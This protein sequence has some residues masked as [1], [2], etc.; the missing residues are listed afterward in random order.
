MMQRPRVCSPTKAR[1]PGFEPQSGSSFNQSF[2]KHSSTQGSAS[3]FDMDSPGV[4]PQTSFQDPVSYVAVDR[5]SSSSVRRRLERSS[6]SS[7]DAF[8]YGTAR[9]EDRVICRVCE[10]EVLRSLFVYSA[11]P[12]PL[13]LT[14]CVPLCTRWQKAR[15]K[16]TPVFVLSTIRSPR[17]LPEA[18]ASSHH[19]PMMNSGCS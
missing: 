13:H 8:S 18:R 12:M 1:I 19:T 7:D 10:T 14:C 17:T 5:Q 16:H 2:K 15:W 9:R 3:S 11:E 6:S 4:R